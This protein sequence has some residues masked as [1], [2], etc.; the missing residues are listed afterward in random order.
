MF[1]VFRHLC[2]CLEVV[3]WT[4]KNWEKQVYWRPKKLNRKLTHVSPLIASTFH[5]A[6]HIF[7]WK[8]F[9]TQESIWINS[10]YWINWK[11]QINKQDILC[12]KTHEILQ[13]FWR[14]IAPAAAGFSP[15]KL[16]K[17]ISTNPPT[18]EP[19]KTNAPPWAN[20][21]MLTGAKS[22]A[23]NVGSPTSPRSPRSEKVIFLLND[24]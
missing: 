12:R 4:I 14:K 20:D 16:K 1:R 22:A 9:L 18:Q 15:P 6:L 8:L 17:A 24:L 11:Y 13:K 3:W 10:E 23:A 5:I 21:R 7:T 19:P 2:S